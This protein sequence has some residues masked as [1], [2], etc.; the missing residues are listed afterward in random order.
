MLWACAKKRRCMEEY[1]VEGAWPRGKPK[2]TWGEIVE[3]DC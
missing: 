2:K 3:K 1:E